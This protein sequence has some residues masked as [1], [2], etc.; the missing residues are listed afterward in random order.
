MIE[1]Q[2]LD[3]LRCPSCR[4][5]RLELGARRRPDLVCRECDTRYPIVDGI[6]DLIAPEREPTP[7]RY[8]TESLENFIAGVYDF[9]APIMSM[10]I[11]RCSPLR[12]VDHEN[13]AL[14]RAQGGLYVE[15]P[16]GTGVALAPVV[17][18]YHDTLIV[19][20]DKSWNMLYKAQ[21]RLRKLAAPF[22]LV[23][24][25]YHALPLATGAVQSLQSLNGL[26]GFMDRVAVLD[27]FHRCLADD[28]FFS[29]SALVRAQ[30]D[31]ADALIE[32]YERHGI[33][34][35][36]RSPEYLLQQV[37]GAHFHDVHFETHGAVMFFDGRPDAQGTSD[38]QRR[39]LPG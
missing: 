4:Q 24:A 14:G 11:W 17:A 15:A 18:D 27:E 36:L 2:I 33:Y 5:G 26:H 7:G 16:I 38:E 13:R 39:A 30:T 12:Y 25:D 1:P 31:V 20:I 3:H 29:G 28:G 19:G 10:A 23:R 21:R 6:P 37:R 8:R 35:M 32:R 34:P 22:Q 9:V